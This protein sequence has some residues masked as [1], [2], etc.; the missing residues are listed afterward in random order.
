M[1]YLP[2]MLYSVRMTGWAGWMGDGGWAARYRS[3]NSPET[4]RPFFAA[5]E[6]MCAFSHSFRTTNLSCTA[7]FF[8]VVQFVF[9]LQ[10]IL[11]QYSHS[12]LMLSALIY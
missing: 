6:E 7:L 3:R 4:K 12:S 2:T 1:P 5:T 9:A 10:E 11:Q 8:L